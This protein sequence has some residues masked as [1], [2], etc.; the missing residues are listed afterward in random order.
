MIH[1]E[2]LGKFFTLHNQGGV[3][4][5]V[6][7]AAGFLR[8]AGRMRGAD[9]RKRRG[10]VDRDAHPLR[11][12]PRRAGIVGA[13]RGPRPDHRRPRAR[14]SRCGARRWATCRNSCAWCRGSPRSTWW[15]SLLLALGRPE[16]EARRTRARSVGAAAHP[17]GALAALAHH[18]LGRRAAAREH[19]ARFCPCLPGVAAG[20]ADGKPRCD[21][22]RDG[23]V[24]DRGGQGGGCGH[25]RHLPRHRRASARGRPGDRRQPLRAQGGGMNRG[26]LI[27][28]VGPSGAGKDSVMEALV[29]RRPDLHRVRR[30]ITRP[31]TAGGEAF[32]RNFPGAFR[33]AGGRWRFRAVLEG[34]R[35]VLR[36]AGERCGMSSTWGRDA[37]G[38][39][40]AERAGQGRTAFSTR[41]M[42]CMSPHGPMCW[43]DRLAARG[44][45]SGAGH[46]TAALPPGTCLSRGTAGDRDRQFRPA[47]GRGGA[48]ACRALPRQ[49]VANGS[50]GTAPPHPRP[51]GRGWSIVQGRGST[52]SKWRRKG[53]AGLIGGH[54]VEAAGER[55]VKP[56]IPPS[57][58]GNP[59]CIRSVSCRSVRRAF[60]RRASSASEG[61]AAERRRGLRRWPRRGRRVPRSARTGRRR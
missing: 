31:E 25:R 28:V 58:R 10:Q 13:H 40:V 57:R 55:Q 2:N 49:G 37:L 43:A 20:R 17:S 34:P 7:A 44:R 4:I 5:P 16:E 1:V 3:T 30:V 12:L 59:N 39:P 29:A 47:R 18:L 56:E 26:R 35:P 24:A 41:S 23:P 27:G 14:S 6:L 46:C 54:G 21:Q 53:R 15:P 36:G 52:G 60:L 32:R 8:G 42:C 61:G 48:R 33:R 45:E 38:E 22:P 19:R 50:G 11:Q 51:S 9:R